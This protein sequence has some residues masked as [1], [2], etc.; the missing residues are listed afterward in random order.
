[1]I[2]V[3]KKSVGVKISGDLLGQNNQ[4]VFDWLE[5]T[6]Y[7]NDLTII[8]GGG[9]QIN[10]AFVKKGL[11]IKFCP[12]GRICE[13]KQQRR[14]AKKILK[15]NRKELAK[16]LKIKGIKANL[17]LPMVKIGKKLCHVNGDIVILNAYIEYDIV[18]ILTTKERE[19]RKKR[20]LENLEKIFSNPQKKEEGLE[21]IQ[22]IG[23]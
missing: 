10:E 8:V 4:E 16:I 2:F 6:A 13:T 18:F 19:E 20:W 3:S 23:F 11:E 17:V 12:F 22:I 5:N 15:Q 9:T 1:M 14:L 7:D 21:K